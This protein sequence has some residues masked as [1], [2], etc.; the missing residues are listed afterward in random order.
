VLKQDE[1]VAAP[2]ARIIETSSFRPAMW[3]VASRAGV[4][5]RANSASI[6]KFRCREDR[7]KLRLLERSDLMEI[8][9]QH[10]QTRVACPLTAHAQDIK[11]LYT[12][13]SFDKD[14]TERLVAE[15]VEDGV[16]SHT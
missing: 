14:E 16:A 4:G 15:A 6:W 10:V 7:A 13:I 12:S 8:V 2:D 1:Q 9:A 5:L 3:K 11:P